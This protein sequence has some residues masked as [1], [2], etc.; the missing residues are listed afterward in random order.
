MDNTTFEK[1]LTAKPE[2][3]GLS[4]GTAG[5][6]GL[7]AANG[8]GFAG[9][10]LNLPDK[11]RYGEPCNGCGMCCIAVQC[12]VSTA[13]F[14]EREI[15]P[16]LTQAGRSLVCGLM[17]DTAA[18]VPDT[19]QWGGKTLTEVFALMIGSGIG[20]DAQADGEPD[21]PEARR[22]MFAAAQSKISNASPEA[23]MLV[24]YFRARL[25]GATRMT[26]NQTGGVGVTVE[27]GWLP[28]ET[29]PKDGLILLYGLLEP[30]PDA[31]QLYG[32]LDRPTR[33]T[34]YWDEIDGAWCPMGST[35]EGPWFH[36]THWQHLPTPPEAV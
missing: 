27:N 6:T 22:I 31:A 15:C 7:N 21:N 29:A 5:E 9:E 23:R 8:L 24:E 2:K 20:C 1:A 30:H 14:G 28:I 13:L 11:P 3:P 25:F 19:T 36:P 17:I 12:V 10:T 33:V 26:D 4:G 34:G 32:N 16:A 35:W 18:Y